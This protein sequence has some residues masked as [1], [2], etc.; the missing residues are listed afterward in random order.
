M[1]NN[2]LQWLRHARE[3]SGPGFASFQRR[4]TEYNHE[5]MEAGL[6]SDRWRE[7]LQRQALIATAEGE[8]LEETR[9]AIAPW[10]QDIPGDPDQFIQWYEALETSR[11]G[12]GRSTVSVARR[13][14]ERTSR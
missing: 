5:R 7:D 4:L 11:T 6:P 1:K 12:P 14:G 3:L 8:F 2:N 13:G 10:V 9:R